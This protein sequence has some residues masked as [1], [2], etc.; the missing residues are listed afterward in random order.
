MNMIYDLNRYPEVRLGEEMPP[1]P[2]LYQDLSPESIHMPV[3]NPEGMPIPGGGVGDRIGGFE[4]R[5]GGVVEDKKYGP[6]DFADMP[7]FQAG[8]AALFD[9]G[10]AKGNLDALIAERDRIRDGNRANEADLLTGSTADRLETKAEL[11]KLDHDIHEAKKKLQVATMVA[12][13]EDRPAL[14]V[15]KYHGDTDMHRGIPLYNE[16]DQPKGVLDKE[17]NR[18]DELDRILE[19]KDQIKDLE[20]ANM[21]NIAALMHGDTVERVEALQK[22]NDLRRKLQAAE[23]RFKQSSVVPSNPERSG[24]TEK[25]VR[26]A[27]ALGAL[28]VGLSIPRRDNKL[29]LS[30]DTV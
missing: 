11:N 17:L 19:L 21:A 10:V 14:K 8:M 29:V 13:V 20:S 1:A 27:R 28:A 16:G 25:R 6:E 15:P 3:K 24:E 22:L 5:A 30:L 9:P 26:V 7:D 12:E 18:L 23:N 4:L 2:V